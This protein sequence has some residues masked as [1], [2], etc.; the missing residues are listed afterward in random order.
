MTHGSRMLVLS[1]A[2][3]LGGCLA[4]EP[5][6]SGERR[7]EAPQALDGLAP[8]E[9]REATTRD[10]LD[11]RQLGV[12]RESVGSFVSLT[13][14][15]DAFCEGDEFCCNESCSIC[16]PLVGGT[17]TL[18]VCDGAPDVG[19]PCGETACGIGEI[20]CEPACG[21][22]A[23]DLD[24]CP[25]VPCD[26]LEVVPCGDGYCGAGESCC[27]EACGICAPVGAACPFVLCDA[28]PVVGPACGPTA[29]ALGEVC[30][31]ALC[32][33]CA[34]EGSGCP[35]LATGPCDPLRAVER[36]SLIHI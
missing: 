19:E 26:Q 17:C 16:A 29:C 4:E 32:G 21:Q 36:L 2:T 15:G 6:E 11:L 31:D 5:E 23:V 13:P 33:I 22:C 3:A 24:A 9:R 8:R 7:G 25:E 12:E 1:V 14:C 10:Q 35:S 34:P 30:C 28:E 20:C 18:Q 27:N